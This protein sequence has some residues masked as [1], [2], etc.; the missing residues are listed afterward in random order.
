MK[1]LKIIELKHDLYKPI[2]NQVNLVLFTGETIDI[3]NFNED[4]NQPEK[5]THCAAVEV[6]GTLFICYGDENLEN[7]LKKLKL[8]WRWIG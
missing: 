1:I 8:G 5:Y 2:G 6:N 3:H 7:T 4:G